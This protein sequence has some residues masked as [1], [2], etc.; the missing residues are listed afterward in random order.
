MLRDINI[1]LVIEEQQGNRLFIGVKKW[2]LGEREKAR[3]RKEIEQG[4]KW[5]A[6]AGHFL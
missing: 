2:A 3:A 1:L 5:R 4:E 6:F